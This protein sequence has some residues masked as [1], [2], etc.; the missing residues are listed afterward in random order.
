[1]HMGGLRRT[2]AVQ[3]MELWGVGIRVVF[4][5]LAKGVTNLLTLRFR[6]GVSAV[7][8]GRFGEG[9]A[10]L[11]AALGGGVRQGACVGRAPDSAAGLRL[12]SAGSRVFPPALSTGARTSSL[13]CSANSSRTQSNRDERRAPFSRRRTLAARPL[14]SREA[15]W[16][17]LCKKY[18]FNLALHVAR[19]YSRWMHRAF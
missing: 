4:G 14:M 5:V 10:T 15:H 17:T 1:M 18:A 9:D 12:P 19:R 3:E 6:H 7:G 11:A 2:V 16:A 8:E 13:H